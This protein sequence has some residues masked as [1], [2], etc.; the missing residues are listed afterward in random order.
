MPQGNHSYQRVAWTD[1]FNTPT[2]AQLREGLP[3]Q[4]RHLFDQLRR[5]ITELDDVRESFAWHGDCWH[6]T[7]E[8]HTRHSDEPLALVVPSPTDLQLAMPV[9][10]EFS[11]LLATRRLKRAVR[12]GLDLVAEPFDN[13]WGVWSINVSSVLDDLQDIIELRLSQLAKRA[14]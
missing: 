6:W 11:K 8:Y 1:R 14:G 4:S 5:R 10:R 3:A 9:T 13:R 7:L 2:I 12:D